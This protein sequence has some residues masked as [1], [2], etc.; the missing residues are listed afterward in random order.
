MKSFNIIVQLN[1]QQVPELEVLA[2]DHEC[3]CITHQPPSID[4]WP[5]ET[6]ELPSNAEVISIIS[7]QTEDDASKFHALLQKEFHWDSHLEIENIL[8]WIEY[9]K[10]YMEPINLGCLTILPQEPLS[11]LA[12]N[13]LYLPAGLAFGTGQHATT[14]GCLLLLQKMSCHHYDVIDFGCG[15]GILGL[16]ALILGAKHVQAHDHDHQALQATLAH[17]V[18]HQLTEKLTIVTDPKSLKAVNVLCANILF[19]PL[20]QL[21]DRFLTLLHP[22]GYAVF[23]GVLESQAHEFKKHYSNY[24]S[25]LEEIYDDGWSSFLMQKKQ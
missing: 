1:T 10:P 9:H 6:H 24:F 14:R 7:F 2:W 5:S 21:H 4:A 3:H 22:Y 15:S 13:T 20:I 11:T 8:P 17:T 16:A 23:S 19:D 18:S 12:D 25:L